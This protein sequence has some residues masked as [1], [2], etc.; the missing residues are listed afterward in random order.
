MVLKKNPLEL[1][2]KR[3]RMRKRVE[4][5][6]LRDWDHLLSYHTIYH[7]V[8]GSLFLYVSIYFYL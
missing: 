6:H 8:D 2:P 3:E 7:W 1:E 4:L 5:G